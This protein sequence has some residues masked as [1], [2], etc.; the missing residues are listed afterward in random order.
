LDRGGQPQP[1]Q[2]IAEVVGDDGEEKPHIVRPEAVTG[3]AS[4]VGRGL[5]FLDPLFGSA[6]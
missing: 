4:P 1:T 5:S 6:A 2:Q 3:E